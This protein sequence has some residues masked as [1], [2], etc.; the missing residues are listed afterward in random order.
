MK[1]TS[2]FLAL[3]LCLTMIM[4]GALAEDT[5]APYIPGERMTALFDAAFDAGKVVGGNMKLLFDLDVDTFVSTPE[6]AAMLE[7]L[8]QTI[9]ASSIDMGMCKIEGGIRLELT[10]MYAPEGTTGESIGAALELTRE[11]LAI[12]SN[13]I[14]GERV[15]AQWETVLAMMGMDEESIAQIMAIDETTINAMFEELGQMLGQYIA[16]AAQLAEPYANVIVEFIAGLP[17]TLEEGIAAESGFPA[18]DYELY[19]TCTDEDMAK[20]VVMLADTLE[21]D[22]TLAPILDSLLLEASQSS[23]ADV[24]LMA[25]GQSLQS[26]AELCAMLRTGAA[27]LAQEGGKYELIV[28]YCENVLPCYLLLH[29]TAAN[30]EQNVL[31]MLLSADESEMQFTITCFESDENDEIGDHFNTEITLQADPNNPDAVVMNLTLSVQDGDDA[32]IMDY[33]ITSAPFTTEDNLPGVQ[34]DYQFSMSESSDDVSTRAVMLMQ[35]SYAL[36]AD[37]GEANLVSGT[38]DMYVDDMHI[39]FTIE[40]GLSAAPSGDNL[41]GRYYVLEAVPAVGLEQ[42]GF[43]MALYSKDH[44]AAASAALHVIALETATDEEIT[45]LMNTLNNSLFE[46]TQK[47]FTL[48][49][50]EILTVMSE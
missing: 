3:V 8:E 20:L 44:D 43:D 7:A 45:A 6:D 1:R 39:P 32:A 36:T 21:K 47:I 13:L 9:A 49:P 18:V 5:Q 30:G 24:T 11:G 26:T 2:L 22:E 14:Q 40:G 16:V 46:K 12:E 10:G 42:I 29:N 41:A 31:M 33:T 15:S 19:I 23:G 17:M 50:A 4:P 28:G 35:S 38:M 37:D 25:D 34:S 27:E 48:L